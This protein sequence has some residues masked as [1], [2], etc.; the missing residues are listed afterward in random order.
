MSHSREVYIQHVAC[1]LGSC[2]EDVENVCVSTYWL[3]VLEAVIFALFVVL[4]VF[5]IY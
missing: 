1:D 5:C 2:W 3:Y 4:F